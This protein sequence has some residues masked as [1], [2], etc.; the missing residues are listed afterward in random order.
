MVDNNGVHITIVNKHKNKK[1]KLFFYDSIVDVT[2]YL[3]K[4]IQG[5]CVV[6]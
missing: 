2:F 3:S 1:K 5:L 4:D 6:Y